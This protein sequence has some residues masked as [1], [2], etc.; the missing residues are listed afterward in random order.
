MRAVCEGGD[1]VRLQEEP[2]LVSWGEVA[3]DDDAAGPSVVTGEQTACSRC[4]EGRGVERHD[5]AGGE[6]P[7]CP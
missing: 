6:Q 7:G 1:R 5:I 3:E 4:G 2:P